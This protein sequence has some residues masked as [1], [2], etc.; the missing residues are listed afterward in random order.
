MII[1]ALLEVWN[2]IFPQQKGEDM[3]KEQI[4]SDAKL[5][6]VQGQDQL[7]SDVLGFVH[8]KALEE[9]PPGTG[10]GP[11]EEEIQARIAAAVAD[12]LAQDEVVDQVKIDELNGMIAAL[13]AGQ[14]QLQA[15]YE[16]LLGK[17]QVEAA[18]LED[19]KKSQEEL[20]R[21][22]AF[23]KA[24]LSP[25]APEPQPEPPVVAEG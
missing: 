12:A 21:I 7:L 9:N 19:L 5:M 18:R 1:E 3:S 10:G 2:S 24:L 25:P 8:D 20:E 4:V 13:Q 17:E 6:F 14:S 11:S 23:L 15:Q 22:A 16:E